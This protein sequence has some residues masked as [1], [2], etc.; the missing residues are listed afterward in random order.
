[1]ATPFSTLL[2]ERITSDPRSAY[3]VALQ[4]A[5][6]PSSISRFLK[7]GGLQIDAVGRLVESLDLEVKPRQ[8]TE[9]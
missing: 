5:I 1:M 6:Q 2:R 4:S 8:T 7:G 3:H 9:V